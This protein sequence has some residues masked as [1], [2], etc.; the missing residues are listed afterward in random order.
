ML[1]G[2]YM[3]RYICD[4]DREHTVSESR[5]LPS[6]HSSSD[7]LTL[8]SE[9]SARL[10]KSAITTPERRGQ[11]PTSKPL[12]S[13][14]SSRTMPLSRALPFQLG[15]PPT[16]SRAPTLLCLTKLRRHQTLLPRLYPRWPPTP[17]RP[18]ILPL[19]FTPLTP[20][21]HMLSTKVAWLQTSLPPLQAR[22]GKTPAKILQQRP[23]RLSV[24]RC[25]RPTKAPCQR[26]SPPLLRA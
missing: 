9:H 15:V 11:K 16:Q 17:L 23:T 14:V 1:Q 12:S 21:M 7:P 8:F 6:L 2:T 26:A 4:P 25:L 3:Q 22:N 18:H 20:P 10:V 5:L 19:R 24:L 13:Y